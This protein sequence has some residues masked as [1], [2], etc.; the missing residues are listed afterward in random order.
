MLIRFSGGDARRLYCSRDI[1][2]PPSVLV[3]EDPFGI[4]KDALTL[5][6]PHREVF[7]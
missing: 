2:T 5:G 6:L 7:L 1:Y 3:A 4:G